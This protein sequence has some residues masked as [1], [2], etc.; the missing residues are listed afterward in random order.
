MHRDALP[1]SP[2]S[3]VF[4]RGQKI[5]TPKAEKPNGVQPS[6]FKSRAA[7]DRALHETRSMVN[8]GPLIRRNLELQDEFLSPSRDMVAY[9]LPRTGSNK[10]VK[11]EYVSPISKGDEANKVLFQA[12]R[13]TRKPFLGHDDIPYSTEGQQFRLACIKDNEKIYEDE[14]II[15]ELETHLVT[16]GLE[17]NVIYTNKSTLTFEEFSVT[18]KSAPGNDDL[19]I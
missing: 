16:G 14:A 8:L 12:P 13:V 5:V 18:Y 1:S 11:T 6:L 4:R 17:V 7:K 3:E 15:I 9:T 10:M 2:K 19:I